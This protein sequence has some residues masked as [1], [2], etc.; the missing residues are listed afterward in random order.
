MAVPVT[1][2][3]VPAVTPYIQY[4]ATELQ[5]V[6][7]YPFPITQDSDL[8]VV[9][10]GVVQLTDVDYTVSG[11]GNSTGGNAT[12]NVGGLAAGSIVTL[13][14]NVPIARLTQLAQNGTFFSSNFNNEFNRLYLIAQQLQENASLCLNIPI[15]NAPTPVTTLTPALY[16]GKYLGFDINGNPQPTLP[17]TVQV[18]ASGS[19]LTAQTALEQAAGIVPTNYTYLP[20]NPLRYGAD[21][22]GVSD[23]T[24]AFANAAIAVAQN[25][26]PTSIS[27][28]GM[29]FALAATVPVPVGTYTV[30]SPVST[31]INTTY[32]MTDGAVVTGVGNLNGVVSRAGERVNAFTFGVGQTAV[33]F[34][35]SI[36]ASLEFSAQI[37]GF[38]AASQIG[39]YPTRDS[40]ALFVQNNAAAATATIANSGTTYSSTAITFTTPLTATQLAQ[41]RIGMIF[42]TSHGPPYWSGFVQSWTATSI[43]VS[44][45]YKSDNS[46]AG[47]PANGTGGVLSQVTKIWGA[48]INAIATTSASLAGIELGTFNK[49]ADP[50]S[51][52][53]SPYYWGFDSVSLG[54]YPGSIAFYARGSSAVG[55]ASSWYN[56]FRSDGNLIGF[57]ADGRSTANSIGFDVINCAVPIYVANSTGS[58]GINV[59]GAFNGAATVY[60][61]LLNPT[62]GAT[63]A[64]AAVNYYS[65]P[66]LA[67][68]AAVTTIYHYLASQGTFGAA[69][70]ATNQIGFNIGSLTG[71]TNNYGVY[72]SMTAGAANWFLYGAGTAQSLL[73]GP[74]G[75][76]G[77]APPAQ[78]TGWGTPVG[79]AV[80]SSYNI[81]D[82][83]G[84]NSNTN[85]AVAQI[86]TI[87]KAFGLL[88]T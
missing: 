86:L 83:G 45:W 51:A 66:N 14:R 31:N 25:A 63:V 15:S 48:N 74:L 35:V 36:G 32:L 55:A 43:T 4:V 84:S 58:V 75:I 40:V 30:A 29:A 57:Y 73:G 5:T 11:V 64:T 41:I 85:K 70:T 71:A 8:V 62:F 21:P 87:L 47:T 60:G 49:Y 42:D 38:T 6:F 52:T 68:G 78:S 80:I 12:S 81:T 79:G 76:N 61:V 54:T 39:N 82:A 67:A 18:P 1:L 17:A 50:G 46:G 44:N 77:N 37:M 10:D 22:T 34:N 33:G 2:S 3:Q 13:Y 24:T 19:I 53:A 72:S 59:T 7:P 65:S 27:G 9:Y 20:G 56:G 23:S 69:A 28:A 16:A 26:N 88:A